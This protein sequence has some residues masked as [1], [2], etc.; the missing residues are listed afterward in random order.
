[1]DPTESAATEPMVSEWL[2]VTQ[3]M[4][5]QF[6]KVT[7]DPDPMHQDPDWA[8]RNSPFGHTIAYG[9]LTVSLLTKLLYSARKGREGGERAGF[10]FLNYG[11]NR[12]RLVSPVRA[13]ARIRGHFVRLGDA[14]TTGAGHP[15]HRHECRIEIERAS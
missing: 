2:Q 10:A 11:F 1:M 6:G 12:L 4:I 15:I 5:D 7:L 8:R 9:F 14:G 3:S 13:G